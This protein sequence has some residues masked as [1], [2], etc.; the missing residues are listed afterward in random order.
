MFDSKNRAHFLSTNKIYNLNIY[1]Q[2]YENAAINFLRIYIRFF[3]IVGST[4]LCVS[5]QP[6]DIYLDE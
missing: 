1:V 2:V 4:P 5:V 6:I 3:D